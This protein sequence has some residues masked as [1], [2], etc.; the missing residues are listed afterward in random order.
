MFPFSTIIRYIGDNVM[1][2]DLVPP[3]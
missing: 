2:A 1:A 3:D